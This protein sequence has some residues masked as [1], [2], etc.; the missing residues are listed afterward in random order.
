MYKKFTT[1]RLRINALNVTIN[2]KGLYPLKFFEFF[3]HYKKGKHTM[4]IKSAVTA[5]CVLLLIHCTTVY[6]KGNEHLAL[7]NY[8]DAAAEFKQLVEIDENDY[9]A[10]FG[11]GDAYRGKKEFDAAIEAYS[12]ALRLKPG[13][14]EVESR[15]IETRL[16]KG[17]FLEEDEKPREARDVY[18]ELKADN[19]DYMPVYQALAQF[20]YRNGSFDKARE[21]FEHIAGID[22]AD[23][24]TYEELGKLDD[25]DARAAELFNAAKKEYDTKYYYEAAASF[26][27]VF[28]LK[29]DHKEAKYMHYLALGRHYLKGGSEMEMWNAIA[30]FGNA[31]VIKPDEPELQFYMARAYEKKDKNDYKMPIEHYKKVIELAPESELAKE[32]EKKIKEITELKEKMEKFFKKK[33]GGRRI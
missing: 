19:P 14:E 26:K 13:W 6:N 15:I 4:K 21:N 22:P 18:E 27:K 23:T 11:L 12:E 25:I 8:D 32:S 30:A 1:I 3:Q 2:Q 5:G 10:Y 9:T 17:N 16:E 24:L 33:K 29:P 31:T 20:Y 28:E 7:Q